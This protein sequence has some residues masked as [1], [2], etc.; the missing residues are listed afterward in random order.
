[1]D[2]KKQYEEYKQALI[3]QNDLKTNEFDDIDKE[4]D[5]VDLSCKINLT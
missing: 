1:M 2:V 5:E 3:Q 4:L